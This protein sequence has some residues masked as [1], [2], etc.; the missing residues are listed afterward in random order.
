LKAYSASDEE[1]LR[2]RNFLKDWAGEGFLTEAQYQLMEQETVC[3]LRRTNI[4][5]R[6]VLFLFTLMV[7]GAAAGLFFT[8][9]LS[10]PEDRPTGFFLLI[11]AVI[12]YAAA[13]HAV[14]WARLYRYG[15][16]E[17]LAVCSVV[18]LCG[19]MQAAL[20]GPAHLPTPDAMEFVV[21]AAGALASLWIWHRFGL[22]YAFAAAMIFVVWP[23]RYWSSSHAVQ[24][25]MV[26]AFYAAGLIIVASVRARYRLTYLNGRYSL[27]EALLWFGIYVAINL[28]LSSLNLPRQWWSGLQTSTEFSRPFYWSTW[29]LI[30]FMPPFV[31]ARGLRRK[32]R[33][34]IAA[35]AM[36]AVLTLVTNKPYLGWRRQTWDPMLLGALLAG[37]ALFVRRWLGAGMGGIR[38]GFTARRLSGRDKA[39]MN[40]GAAGF[41]LVSPGSITRGAQGGSPEVRFGGGDSA[42]GGASSDF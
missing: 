13:E 17:A 12:S 4:F 31:L 3:E 14:S 16:E 20:F 2:A 23:P 39:W 28:E 8:V 15:I 26:A 40:A 24:H 21:P 10:R 9:F 27:A 30:W 35:G 6:L 11:F 36:M 19:G 37:I 32:D 5:L 33:L 18:F 42:G 22:P 25:V 41:G 29:V 38:Q 1:A 7:V 34:V